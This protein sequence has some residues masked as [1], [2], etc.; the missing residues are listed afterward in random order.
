MP[1][2][3]KC[4]EFCTGSAAKVAA[5]PAAPSKNSVSENLACYLST[6]RM[7]SN[8]HMVVER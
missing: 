1:R 2:T 8:Q 3:L 5:A 4:F 7:K 6:R